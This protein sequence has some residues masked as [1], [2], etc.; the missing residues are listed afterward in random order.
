MKNYI[1]L[2]QYAKSIRNL[3]LKIE[4]SMLDNNQD[5]LIKLIDYLKLATDSENKKYKLISDKELYDIALSTNKNEILVSFV[6]SSMKEELD[7]EIEDFRIMNKIRTK[8]LEESSGVTNDDYIKGT[9]IYPIYE[10]SNEELI[11]E[12]FGSEIGNLL[13][14]FG[15]TVVDSEGETAESEQKLQEASIP[16][17]FLINLNFIKIILENPNID[18]K[19]K[20]KIILKLSYTEPLIEQY[21]ICENMELNQ[22]KIEETLNVMINFYH[23]KRSFNIIAIEHYREMMSNI[24]NI[25]YDTELEDKKLNLY[26]SM[27]MA[28]YT[29][30]DDI[31]RKSIFRTMEQCVQ[32][33]CPESINIL[34]EEFKNYEMTEYIKKLGGI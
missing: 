21:L 31:E 22:E 33:E 8:L 4:T 6:Y 15:V 20:I 11:E 1:E 12:A 13:V 10:R 7:S 18:E 16:Y 32:T 9:P 2:Y 25:I 5:E 19:D 34:F 27:F 28:Y 23:N 14:E 3:Y 26:I 29:L 17:I 24:I 30:L